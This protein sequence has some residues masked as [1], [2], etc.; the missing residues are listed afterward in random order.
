MEKP[1]SGTLATRLNFW[2]NADVYKNADK[3][4]NKIFL[5]ITFY[6]KTKTIILRGKGTEIVLWA[7]TCFPKNGYIMLYNGIIL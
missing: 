4:S 7:Q 3:K 1:T 5:F 6:I 2:E